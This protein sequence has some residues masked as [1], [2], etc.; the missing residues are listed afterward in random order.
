M[1]L[2]VTRHFDVTSRDVPVSSCDVDFD[3]STDSEANRPRTRVNGDVS[4]A[5]HDEDRLV[6]SLGSLSDRSTLNAIA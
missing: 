2:S 5:K 3:L 4:A 1:R 6:L